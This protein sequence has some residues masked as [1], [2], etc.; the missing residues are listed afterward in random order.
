MASSPRRPIN[1]RACTLLPSSG[2]P[3]PSL[4]AESL[5]RGRADNG[6]RYSHCATGRRPWAGI[7]VKLTEVYVIMNGF[8]IPREGTRAMGF[9]GAIFEGSMQR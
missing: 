9:M 7:G 6:L 5:Y 1:P 3:P 2:K 8:M 4:G